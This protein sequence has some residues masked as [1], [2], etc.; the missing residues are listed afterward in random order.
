MTE[1]ITKNDELYLRAWGEEHKVLKAWESFHGW[2]W[3]ATELNDDGNHFGFVQGTFEEWGYFSESEIMAISTPAQRGS[4]P[5][6]W[7]IKDCDLPHSG[8]RGDA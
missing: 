5:M 1:L 4:F 3:F 2:Y 7:P 8:R 6:A